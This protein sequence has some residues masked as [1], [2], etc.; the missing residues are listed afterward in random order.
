[1]LISVGLKN[2]LL[3]LLLILLIHTL[4]QRILIQSNSNSSNI[5]NNA[6]MM[7]HMPS[8]RISQSQD[9]HDRH[10]LLLH[11][12]LQGH[13]MTPD[14]DISESCV[15]TKDNH[16]MT[17]IPSDLLDYVFGTT[18]TMNEPKEVVLMIQ[19]P[20]QELTQEQ[21]NELDI[22]TISAA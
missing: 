16:Q 11:H 7:S 18:T 10:G 13:F 19:E 1:M 15:I 4:L 12:E 14:H 22:G 6:N 2:T 3:F 8:V 20:I 17:E 21:V 9:T 5:S